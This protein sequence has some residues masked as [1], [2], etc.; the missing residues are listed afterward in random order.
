[1]ARGSR[2]PAGMTH[3][4]FWYGELSQRGLQL[5]RH[6]EDTQ[7]LRT[8]KCHMHLSYRCPPLALP[9]IGSLPA[10][11]TARSRCPAC[12]IQLFLDFF[13]ENSI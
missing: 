5:P 6:Q 11:F 9:G 13:E 4:L 1:M 12:K 2:D 7:L 8:R 10:A 3:M